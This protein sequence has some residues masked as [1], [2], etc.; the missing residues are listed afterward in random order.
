MAVAFL[1]LGGALEGASIALLIPLITLL[2]TEAEGEAGAVLQRLEQLMPDA[3]RQTH[4][5]VLA[6]GILVLVITKNVVSYVGTVLTT[7]LRESAVREIRRR[8][9]DG[10]LHASADVFDKRTT[11]DLSNVLLSETNM[12]LRQLDLLTLLAQRFAVTASY[13][14]AI[15]LISWQLTLLTVLLGAALAL[16]AVPLWRRVLRQGHALTL[17]NGEL[18][19][20]LTETFGG[21]R[22]LR[23]TNSEDREAQQFAAVNA[24]QA[25]AEAVMVRTST[26]L[27]GATETIGVAGAMALI[28]LANRLV[29]GPGGVGVAEFLAFCF[30]LL[31][32]LP[33]VNQMYSLQA[34]IVSHTSSSEKVLEWL[35]LPRHPARPFGDAA[36]DTL[37]EGIRF[38]RVCFTYQNGHRALSDVS[39]FVRTGEQLAIVGASGAGKSTFA[40]LLLRLRE[41]TSGRIT[42]DGRDYW[43]IEPACYHRF[44][45]FVEQE[46]FLFDATIAENVAYGVPGVTRDAVLNALST[47][48]LDALVARLPQG[49]DTMV[50][51]RGATLSGGQRQRMAIARALVRSP[52]L[53]IL[54]E[55]TSAL[56]PSTEREVVDAIEAAG[57]GRTTIVIAHRLSTI[58][59]A[60]RVIE[61]EEG[62][63]R[64][65]ASVA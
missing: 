11:G 19:R 46:P 64:D 24:E 35:G 51:E 27:H 33:G 12:V 16:L 21:I 61:F 59:R 38:E 25:R 36:I 6:L 29:L 45:A 62:R 2:T 56:D 26:V 22:V 34:G 47:V 13:F 32:L 30:G 63:V 65:V 52:Q 44:V 57:V 23:A 3:S 53:L 49:I 20:R 7:S 43:D 5:L 9:L 18:A 17:A 39:L 54:D 60:D 14:A 15:M 1:A 48:K 37:R 28:A 31:R 55:P 41:P 50:G 4:V 10:V 40:S 58:E 42:F 8:L